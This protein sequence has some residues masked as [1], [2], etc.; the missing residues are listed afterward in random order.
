VKEV[1]LPNAVFAA[2][3]LASPVAGAATQYPSANFEPKVLYQDA[4]YIAKS[5]GK[6]ASS[7]ASRSSS[8]SSSAVT[9]SPSAARSE[10]AAAT[11]PARAES[12]PEVSSGGGVGQIVKENVAILGIIGGLIGFV[13]WSSK[14]PGSKDPA[15]KRTAA[16]AA[17]SA[18]PAASGETGV[19]RYLKTIPGAAI[20]SVAETGVARYLKSLSGAAIASA[21]ETGVGR[22]LKNLPATAIASAADTG[23][24]RYLKSRG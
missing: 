5:G 9:S 11:A 16:V 3:L 10:V 17:S 2:L 14:R 21:A 18:A 24:A 1:N 13:V 20:A 12:A 19:A 6:P 15:V 4:D 23:V 22:Y 7:A 8:N